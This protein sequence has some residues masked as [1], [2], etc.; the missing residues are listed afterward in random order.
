METHRLGREVGRYT[1]SVYR[2]R[3]GYDDSQSED[4]DDC[5]TTFGA[6][7]AIGTCCP[8]GHPFVEYNVVLSPILRLRE[9]HWSFKLRTAGLTGHVEL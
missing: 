2:C 9:S 3:V 1:R 8:G 4:A 5:Y 7:L 6:Q